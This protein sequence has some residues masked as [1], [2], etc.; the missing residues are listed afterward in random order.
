MLSNLSRCFSVNDVFGLKRGDVDVDIFKATE[1]RSRHRTTTLVGDDTDLLI[2]LLHYSETEN[3]TIYFSCDDVNPLDAGADAMDSP[4]LPAL[5]YVALAKLKTPNNSQKVVIDVAIAV[6][7]RKTCKTN[8]SKPRAVV[9][10]PGYQQ[11][12]SYRCIATETLLSTSLIANTELNNIGH[13]LTY[14]RSAEQE[15]AMLMP[16]PFSSLTNQSLHLHI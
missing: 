11:P 10:K 4:A 13:N 9:R 12:V 7:R 14:K 3:T 8:R 6:L 15:E 5:L 16:W 2:W 1:E